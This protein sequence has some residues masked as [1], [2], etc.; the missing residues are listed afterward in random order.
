MQVLWFSDSVP[1]I[2]GEVIEAEQRGQNG[3]GSATGSTAAELCP[4]KS[5]RR[6]IGAT[7]P[8]L[9]NTPA[10]G[11]EQPVTANEIGRSTATALAT[12]PATAQEQPAPENKT[13]PPPAR[14]APPP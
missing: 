10:I 2:F 6:A 12:P 14:Q 11:H 8:A 5:V 9:G 3:W 13:G 7:V 4:R 1:A